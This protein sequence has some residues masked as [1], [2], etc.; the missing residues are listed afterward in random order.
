M[1]VLR[2]GEILSD[3]S[4]LQGWKCL[5]DKAIELIPEEHQSFLQIQELV[6]GRNLPWGFDRPG[7]DDR[8]WEEPGNYSTFKAARLGSPFNLIP[9]PIPPL[10]EIPQRFSG[11]YTLPES[12]ISLADWNLWLTGQSPIELPAGA[13]EIIEINAGELTTGYLE[14]L[15]HSGKGSRVTLLTAESY[16]RR[17]INDHGMIE[18]HK[19]DRLDF[20]NGVLTGLQDD[21]LVAGVGR[22]DS[23]EQ[24]E[25]FWF[26][27]FRFVRLEIQVGDEPLTLVDFKYRET[28]Y[29]LAVKTSVTTSDPE[30]NKIWDISLR[31]LRRCMHETYE[32]CPFYEQLQYAMDTRAQILFTYA[33]AADDRLARKCID[34]FHRSLR[35]DGMINCCYPSYGYNVIPGFALFYIMII[36]DHMMYFGDPH[37]VRDYMRTIDTILTYF[38]CKIRPD[39]LMDKMGGGLLEGGA[40]SFIDWA[41]NWNIGVPNAGD[42]GPLTVEN[43]LYAYTLKRAAELASF[44]GQATLADQY[45]VRAEELIEAVNKLCIASNGYY[46]DGPG[47]DVDY[48][49]HAQ[50]WAVLSEAVQGDAARALMQRTLADGSLSKCTVA[51]AYYLFR[52]VE[53]SGLYAQTAALW[54]PW[55]QML[56][57]NL[58]TCSETEGE[59]TRSDCHAWGSLALYEI[60]QVI[61]GVQTQAPGFAKIVIRP[62]VGFVHSAAGSVITPKGDIKVAWQIL[63]DQFRLAVELPDGE[64]AEII[65]PDGSRH[66]ASSGANDFYCFYPQF[67]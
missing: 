17:Q 30:L 18:L 63:D 8:E 26:R 40:W 41:A 1:F 24:Y 14:L 56:A 64:S 61:L 38:E 49:Q 10:F 34:E 7:F 27:T 48:S 4:T 58:T 37:L 62:Q 23:S 65:L 25:P 15:V 47:Y 36:H 60:P 28:G 42:S 3:L 53:K 29:P 13:H 51:M 33:V 2:S 39:G 43:L 67:V 22:P 6:D 31:T 52:A 57:N 9:R 44:C 45:R 35:P 21:Y 50:V 19:G 66:Q 55:R 11:V 59:V 5:K 32:D 20:K 46:Q 12:T 16:A 54:Q